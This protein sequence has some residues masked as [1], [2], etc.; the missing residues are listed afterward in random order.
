MAIIIEGPDGAGKSTLARRLSRTLEMPVQHAGSACT[1]QDVEARC[2]ADLNNMSKK[3]IMDRSVIISESIYGPILREETLIDTRVWYNEIRE[4]RARVPNVVLVF[5]QP[6]FEE[7]RP[8]VDK[9]YNS[10][11]HE[12]RVKE[13][14]EQLWLRYLTVATAFSLFMPTLVL[15]PLN[16]NESKE[17]INTLLGHIHE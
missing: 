3:I 11:E 9:A 16:G 6:P 5:C 10:P 1:P 15:N 4:V 7:L 2:L 13:Q 14:I 12:Q 8:Q 17:L